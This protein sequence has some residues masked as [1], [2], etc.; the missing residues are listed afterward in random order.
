MGKTGQQAA[1]LP[2]LLSQLKESGAQG[3]HLPMV[4]EPSAT[5]Q[6]RRTGPS[7]AERQQQQRMQDRSAN[8]QLDAKASI[9]ANTAS[10]DNTGALAAM[11]M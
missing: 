8:R 10:A 7:R 5:Q 1:L 9:E 6:A 2:V 4:A 3:V 11:V